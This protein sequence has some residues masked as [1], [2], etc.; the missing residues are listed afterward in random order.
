MIE[1]KMLSKSCPAGDCL[2]ELIADSDSNLN[3]IPE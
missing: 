3:P 1:Y 2:Q